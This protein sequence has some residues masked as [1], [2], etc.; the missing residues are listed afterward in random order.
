MNDPPPPITQVGGGVV[1]RGDALPM[2]YRAVLHGIQRRRADGLPTA[3]LQQLAR[4]LRRAHEMSLERHLL[5]NALASSSCCGGQDPCDDWCSTGEAA[6]L[7]GL[8]RRSVQRMAAEA[9]RLESIRVGRTYLLRLA[10]VLA[11]AERRDR[12]RRQLSSVMGPARDKPSDRP[13]T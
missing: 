1:I 11:L 10:P 6:S 3:D 9:R 5:A 12:D 2:A 4:A 7:L 13:V 8:S